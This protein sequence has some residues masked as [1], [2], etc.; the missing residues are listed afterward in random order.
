MPGLPQSTAVHH[1]EK[2][3]TSNAPMTIFFREL[4]FPRRNRRKM[5]PA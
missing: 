1:F 2:A 4:L 5:G 3:T